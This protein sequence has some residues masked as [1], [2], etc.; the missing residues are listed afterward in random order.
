MAFVTH[1]PLW[2]KPE[3]VALSPGLPAKALSHSP[4]RG[5]AEDTPHPHTRSGSAFPGSRPISS[6]S[7]QSPGTGTAQAPFVP[8]MSLK[9]L[10][11]A[12]ASPTPTR[13]REWEGRG[14]SSPARLCW[15]L[16]GLAWGLPGTDPGTSPRPL[17]LSF[18]S[19][20]GGA[21]RNADSWAELLDWKPSG[22][23]GMCIFK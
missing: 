12:P 5:C 23:P 16:G 17:H 3:W 14:Q 6:P 7:Q 21:S 13:K 1:L 15:A 18:P 22:G 8:L 11:W 10:A 20:S 9:C 19:T 4:G 2:S